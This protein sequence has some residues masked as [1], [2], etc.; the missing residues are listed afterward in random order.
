M[1]AVFHSRGASTLTEACVET[2]FNP[3][4]S[5]GLVT[6]GELGDKEPEEV[7]ELLQL[8]Q[9]SRLLRAAWI[10]RDYPGNLDVFTY[11]KTAQDN[12][13]P[14]I[15]QQKGTAYNSPE[16]AV[17]LSIARFGIGRVRAQQFP[18]VLRPKDERVD[19][20]VLEPMRQESYKLLPNE[21]PIDFEHHP[22]QVLII[23]TLPLP[24]AHMVEM[25]T[26]ERSTDLWESTLTVS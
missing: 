7:G 20:T 5:L 12:P 22:S 14:H 10:A 21:M 6:V 13:K 23:P 15:D 3:A 1:S 26:D 2:V 9:T 11:A 18:E 25:L 19:K 17:V 4:Y 16:R 8:N 24:V